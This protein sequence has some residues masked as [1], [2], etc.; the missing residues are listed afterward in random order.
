V[1][2]VLTMRR[3]VAVL[4]SL[5]IAP[6]LADLYRWVDPETG[7][8]KFS[9]YPPPWFNDAAK[10]GRAPK[11]EVIRPSRTAPA[12]ASEAEGEPAPKAAERGVGRD[13]L[14]KQLAQRVAALA[15]AAPEAM[16][17]ANAE[18]AEPLQQLE[19]LDRQQK[20]SNPGD[21]TVRLEEKAKL[22]GPLESRRS[23]LLQQIS[24][25]GPPPP[26]SPSDK[27]ESAWAG[28]QRSLAA[29]GFVDG[30]IIALDPRKANARHFEMNALIDKTVALWEP[31]V[32][33]GILRKNR[34][35]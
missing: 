33:P 19:R 5:W 1:K 30:A 18:L 14:L 6:A 26:G 11:V 21:E 22:A 35:R 32:D 3:A 16:G 12:F 8:V 31:Y 20:P 7:T 15:S 25:Q 27:I 13:A 34:G 2:F 24:S 28:T 10:Q 23:A 4:I 17:Q 29:L 9:S